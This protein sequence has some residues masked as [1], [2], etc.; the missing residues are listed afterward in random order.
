MKQPAKVTTQVK[1]IDTLLGIA[2]LI[3]GFR[4]AEQTPTLSDIA[5]VVAASSRAMHIRDLDER[6]S[7]ENSVVMTLAKRR[8]MIG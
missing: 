4:F 5:R 2:D 3:V 8:N 6:I 1:P 7:V